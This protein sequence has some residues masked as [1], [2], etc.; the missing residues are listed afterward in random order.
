M[1][2]TATK[3]TCSHKN[4]TVDQEWL[5]EQIRMFDIDD[6]LLALDNK[7]RIFYTIVSIPTVYF[8]KSIDTLGVYLDKTTQEVILG[9]N[10]E[11]FFTK[12]MQER[13]FLLCHEAMHVLLNH[14]HQDSGDNHAAANIAEDIVINESLL[15]DYYFPES[16][17]KTILSQIMLV[18]TVF[19][20]EEI[21]QHHIVK[22][23]C[24]KY[25][26]DLLNKL[27]PAM[28]LKL[29]LCKH[30]IGNGNGPLVPLTDEMLDDLLR[31]VVDKISKEELEALKEEIREMYKK[32]GNVA[33]GKIITLINRKLN[34]K[35]D[36]K[37]ILR[38]EYKSLIDRK[39]IEKY[40]FLKTSRRNSLLPVDL[41]IP[42]MNTVLDKRIA[43][44]NVAFFMDV[45]GSCLNDSQ[46]FF[47]FAKTLPEDMCRISFY[48]FDTDVYKVDIKSKQLR[49]GGGTSFDIIESQC[50]R[51]EKYPDLV[52]ILTDGEGTA[53]TPKHPERWV[54]FLTGDQ[55]QFIHSKSK[56]HDFRKVS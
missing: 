50:N 41:M 46:K 19:S 1:K 28:M 12:T 2:N 51:M 40:G 14:L 26:F 6:Y 37:H 7:N 44:H 3:D 20:P 23:E 13:I 4:P 53:V 49:G 29:K 11:F 24:W 42:N 17:M 33:M 27:K 25:Y 9:I 56:K 22:N 31:D 54:W 35:V 39:E 18:E 32:A 8:T 36:W 10:A 43:K 21:A 48:S 16:K 38:K 34:K 5:D 47:E 30:G 52:I 55:D 45:S 15:N